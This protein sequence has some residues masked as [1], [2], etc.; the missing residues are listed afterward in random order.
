MSAEFRSA[1]SP[2]F[3]AS[4]ARL[5]EG[6]VEVVFHVVLRSRASS[7]DRIVMR[8]QFT[9]GERHSIIRLARMDPA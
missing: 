1:R 4:K 5:P 8:L 9:V 7:G 3:A 6:L 2:S